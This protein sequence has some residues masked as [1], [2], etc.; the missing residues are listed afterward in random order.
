MTDADDG[1]DALDEIDGAR[2]KLNELGDHFIKRGRAM[3]KF[4]QT[5]RNPRSQF[6]TILAAAKAADLAMSV[7]VM[8]PG[9]TRQTTLGPQLRYRRGA[10]EGLQARLGNV[11]EDVDLSYLNDLTSSE[12]TE[13]SEYAEAA[14]DFINGDGPAPDRPNFLPQRENGAPLDAELEGKG[15]VLDHTTTTDEGSAEGEQPA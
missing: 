10:L 15:F 13:L 7:N 9:D 6:S 1:A 5:L 14:L 11:G 2:Q 3:V 12:L 8:L 4:G